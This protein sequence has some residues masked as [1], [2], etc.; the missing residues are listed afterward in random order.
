MNKMITVS[1]TV[2]KAKGV[3]LRSNAVF[4]MRDYTKCHKL[5]D[6]V[7]KSSLYMSV[8]GLW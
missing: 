2:I 1:H 6:Y 3:K 5:H 7:H 4:Y 8:A